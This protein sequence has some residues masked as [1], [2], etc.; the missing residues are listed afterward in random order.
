MSYSSRMPR[1]S[2]SILLL[3]AVLAIGAVGAALVLQHFFGMEPCAW[4]TFQRLVFL[5]VAALAFV[6]WLLAGSSRMGLVVS[7]GLAG[8][9]ALGGAW[10]ALHQQFVA[11][12]SQSC[13]F[14]FADRT[15]MKLRLDESLPWMF[16]ATAS[17]SEANVPLL[18]IPFAAWS[19]A[20][21]LLLAGLAVRAALQVR[22]TQ[23][24]HA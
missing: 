3:C 1:R 15:L 9:A 16:E 17:C 4:C 22:A 6:G 7:S 5:L 18:G 10:A 13:V 12:K 11:S 19:A 8:V 14:T 23:E 21:F 24:N 20:L 2:G